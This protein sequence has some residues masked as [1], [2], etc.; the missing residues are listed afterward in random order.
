MLHTVAVRLMASGQPGQAE[1]PGR[2]LGQ[3]IPPGAGLR[4][5]ARIEVREVEQQ[6]VARLVG[7]GLGDRLEAA[8][9]NQVIRVDEPDVLAAGL[10]QRG[11]AVAAR[12]LRRDMH[13]QQ[14][15]VVPGPG[16]QDRAGLVAG[17]AFGG[18]DLDVAER[19]PQD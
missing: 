11:V 2:G 10:P 14:P 8:G 1:A 17:I 19:L 15:G 7:D 4:L 3:Q 13:G 6:D 9:R 12:P 18:D 5:A 16:V